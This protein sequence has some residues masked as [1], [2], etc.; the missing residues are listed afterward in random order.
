[1]DK[2]C[3]KIFQYDRIKVQLFYRLCTSVT[4]ETRTI[5]AIV[6]DFSNN[7]LNL[8]LGK[9]SDHAGQCIMFSEGGECQTIA[10]HS[11]SVLSD[12]FT[13][14]KSVFSRAEFLPRIT[15]FHFKPAYNATM[16]FLL[17]AKE[18]PIHRDI[19]P[20]IARLVYASHRVE[21]EF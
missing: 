1:M 7:F 11:I 9:I 5:N 20:V 18:L 15:L 14:E 4:I 10:Y 19:V 16:C 13:F 12:T 21:L 6:W 2:W 3:W 8:D 17:I